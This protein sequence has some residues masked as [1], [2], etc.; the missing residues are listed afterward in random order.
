MHSTLPLEHRRWLNTRD[1]AEHGGMSERTVR[2]LVARGLLT[3]H[4]LEGTRLVRI[5]RRELDDLMR[6]Q[7][8]GDH[9]DAA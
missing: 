1:A 8:G 4:R 9:D 7:H 3:A 5:D 2:N 6:A